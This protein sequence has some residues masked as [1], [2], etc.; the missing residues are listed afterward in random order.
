[1]PNVQPDEIDLKE[2]FIKLWKSKFLILFITI[3]FSLI[4]FLI[5]LTSTITYQTSFNIELGKYEKPSVSCEPQSL[6]YHKCTH[7]LKEYKDLYTKTQ[8]K[9][10]VDELN[11]KYISNSNINFIS[12]EANNSIKIDAIS[13]DNEELK[14]LPLESLKLIHKRDQELFELIILGREQYLKNLNLHYN[15]ETIFRDEIPNKKV[16]ITNALLTTINEY[17]TL[18][19]DEA[20]LKS[21]IINSKNISVTTAKLNLINMFTGLFFGLFISILIALFKTRGR[22]SQ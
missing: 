20:Y 8:R 5:H 4:P 21:S 22:V 3:I 14:N 2:I 7:T 10:I 15:S 12:N 19:L 6:G 18:L 9:T 13:E 1:L 16:V 17:K 11:L